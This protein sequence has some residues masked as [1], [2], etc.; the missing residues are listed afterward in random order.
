MKATGDVSDAQVRLIREVHRRLARL[1]TRSQGVI[2]FR[3][4]S[5]RLSEAA[6]NES[7]GGEEPANGEESGASVWGKHF[8]EILKASERLVAL[9]L[10][11]NPTLGSDPIEGEEMQRF[12]GTSSSVKAG[13]GLVIYFFDPERA[14]Q[15]VRIRASDGFEKPETTVTL[16][17][18]ER[19]L[20]HNKS[21]PFKV[22]LDWSVVLLEADGSRS[23][24]IAVARPD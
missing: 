6:I 9:E 12:G 24:L 17:L 4:A 11:L 20:G 18:D 8:G 23:K 7:R 16:R 14:G 3:D 15:G 10:R 19:G 5:Y 21:D 22:P 1:S 2:L 13:A